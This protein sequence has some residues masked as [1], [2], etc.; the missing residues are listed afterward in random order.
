M[1]N[2][3]EYVTKPR[4]RPD[5]RGEEIGASDDARNVPFPGRPDYHAA[6]S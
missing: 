3:V 1:T 4:H 5:F 6:R 2:T